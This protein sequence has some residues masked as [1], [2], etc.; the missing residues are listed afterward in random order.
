MKRGILTLA[1]VGTV[2]I[3][4]LYVMPSV[5]SG[6]ASAET[7]TAT[8]SVQVGGKSATEP[9]RITINGYISEAVREAVIKALKAGGTPAARQA[10]ETLKDLGTIEVLGRS[11]PIKY[12]YSRSSGPG[13]GRII[14]LVT[15]QPIHFVKAG[16][17][18]DKPKAGYEVALALLI[19]D[20]NEAGD[21]EMAPAA[22][23][24]LDDA[25]ALLVDDYGGAKVWLKAV[26]KAK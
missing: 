6:Q 1:I 15:A 14:T 12:A 20:T 21:G 26:A 4:S 13:A 2:A 5:L 16:T 10:L 8:A 3:L 23:I 19:L 17:A 24:K 18:A 9:V 25:G 22:K 7:F 11:T